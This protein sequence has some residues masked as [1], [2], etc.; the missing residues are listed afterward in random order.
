MIPADLASRLRL[1]SQDLPAPVQPATP[2][3]QLTD[4]L[5]D[6]TAGQR[7]MAEIQA[8]LPNGMYR[9][10]VAQRDVTLALP[11]AAKA[12]DTLEL[13]VQESDGKLILAVVA[14][15]GGDDIN[16]K[17]GDSVSTTLSKTGNLIAALLNEVDQQGGH[18]KPAALNA[19]QPLLSQFPDNPADLVPIL[20]ESLSKSGMFYEAHQARWVE[21]K[22]TTA[23]LLQEPQGKLSLPSAFAPAS[24]SLVDS[25]NPSGSPTLSSP[26]HEAGDINPTAALRAPMAGD[27][28]TSSNK[29]TESGQGTTL[30]KTAEPLAH[31]G[32]ASSGVDSSAPRAGPAIHPELTPLVQ[33]QL[34]ALATQ[35]YI[36]QGQVWPGQSMHWE[37]SEEEH[38]GSSDNDE[39][40]LRWQTRLKLNLPQLGGIDATLR[41]GQAGKLELS[42]I[43]DNPAGQTTLQR[44]GPELDQ[45]LQTAGLQLTGFTVSHGEIPG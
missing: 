22:L 23:S 44:A 8:L 4:V 26:P 11:F 7:I 12:G 3:R 29:P 6:L 25:Q 38:K 43:A 32:N 9:A 10:V 21:G 36:W 2:A 18:P 40:P 35:T 1:V 27:A 28:D 5:S 33:Q 37:I 15:K 16:A 14:N 20:K 19:N 31:T 45:A 17:V 39:T 41:L 34:N 24:S 42:L 13:E 30:A